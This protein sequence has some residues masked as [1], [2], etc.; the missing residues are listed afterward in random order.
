MKKILFIIF[1]PFLTFSINIDFETAM[2]LYEKGD[3]TN[4][5]SVFFQL[6]NKEPSAKLSF[7]LGN[8]AYL[9]NKYEEAWYWYE[10]GLNYG[11]PNE[12]L[13]FNAG[14][15]LI[16]IKKY[17]EALKLF[18][19][20]ENKTPLVYLLLSIFYYNI[21][22]YK[23]SGRNIEN[24][25]KE[26]IVLPDSFFNT[27]YKIYF[28][29]LIKQSDY[30]NALRTSFLLE[31]LEKSEIFFINN[32]FLNFIKGQYS[33]VFKILETI[34]TDKSF[35]I[36]SLIYINE[37][38]FSKAI[39]YLDKVKSQNS[40][41][42]K[43]KAYCFYRNG[44]N[45]KAYEF[46]SKSELVLPEDYILKSVILY[47]MGKYDEARKTLEIKFFKNV[48]LNTLINLV[49][50]YIKLKDYDKA[51]FVVDKFLEDFKDYELKIYAFNLLLLQ[52][53]YNEAFS[54]GIEILKKDKETEYDYIFLY[55]MGKLYERQ[56]KIDMAEE[57][58]KKSISLKSDFV[59]PYIGLA[60]IFTLKKDYNKAIDCYLIVIGLLP[61][62]PYYYF[63]LS[64]VFML[65]NDEFSAKR[66]AKI[67]LEKGLD[68]SLIKND[69]LL[70][71][72][73]IDF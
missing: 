30:D 71:K 33:K 68:K 6:F 50:I 38:N 42:N 12:N 40:E 59:Y 8:I 44:M 17:K 7:Y 48:D 22:D 20:I 35:L 3:Y 65:S 23:N 11:I 13:L 46:I 14:I 57:F 62:N 32:A 47:E 45:E 67:S 52:E 58:Y 10:K 63:L 5:Y 19:K 29:S 64:Q 26:S 69:T 24:I 18:E 2:S 34:E 37:K 70:S 1:I 16:K 56:N 31:R 28:Y 15:T 54:Y 21:N 36:I 43:I 25:I 66:Y 53:K 9:Q 51:F 72:L 27:I 4:S 60:G 49:S 55:N 41:I 39:Y 61:E 73:N